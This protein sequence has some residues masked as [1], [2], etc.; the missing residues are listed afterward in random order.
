[1][2][3]KNVSS[4]LYPKT[5]TMDNRDFL[6]ST[7]LIGK[8]IVLLPQKGYNFYFSFEY[9][10][11][12]PH[13]I[14]RTTDPQFYK[15]TEYLHGKAR[16]M[17]KFLGGQDYKLYGFFDDGDIHFYDLKINDN[18]FTWRDL[19]I[20]L[21]IFELP[22]ARVVW[23]GIVNSVEEM[24]ELIA[25]KFGKTEKDFLFR[26]IEEEIEITYSG[27]DR[28]KTAETEKSTLTNIKNYNSLDEEYDD[29]YGPFER[30]TDVSSK[31]LIEAA[32][33]TLA[34]E[35][36][37]PWLTS[38]V[39]T[40]TGEIDTTSIKDFFDYYSKKKNL[41]P[42]LDTLIEEGIELNVPNRSLIFDYICEFIANKITDDAFTISIDIE[43]HMD[44]GVL[45]GMIQKEI[46]TLCNAFI[47]EL[48]NKQRIEDF[49]KEDYIQV[50]ESLVRTS[51]FSLLDDYTTM[52]GIAQ[53]C[54][55]KKISCQEE[56]EKYYESEMAELIV[57]DLYELDPRELIGNLTIE[58]VKEIIHPHLKTIVSKIALQSFEF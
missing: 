19:D 25:K 38:T 44:R 45:F 1:M 18:Y 20:E 32:E 24:T 47:D 42:V 30:I 51:L 14:I 22:I 31:T 57:D 7:K 23:Q 17:G 6:L 35:V 11:L 54:L 8:E 27:G 3:T 43:Q 9:L 56:K 12:N 16:K 4:Y 39:L 50:D 52:A 34:Q 5:Y 26:P 33:E 2:C 21:G 10:D 40:E 58:R 36:K 46:T 55:Y 49:I 48:I 29:L 37:E 41:Q 13:T 15:E 53:G 28:R